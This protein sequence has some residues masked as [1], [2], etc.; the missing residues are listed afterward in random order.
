MYLY[1]T[2]KEEPSLLLR[3][4]LL[5]SI[6]LFFAACAGKPEKTFVYAPTAN[7]ADELQNL[8]SEMRRTET[9]QIAFFAP[10][11]YERSVKAWDRA[12]KKQEKGAS[13]SEVL[14]ELSLSRSYFEQAR[15]VAD[16]ALQS[17][18][19]IAE[20]RER[21]L[22]AG[23]SR[24]HRSDL[25]DADEDLIK[26]TKSFEKKNPDVSMKDRTRLQSRYSSL[27][28][29]SIKASRLGDTV[30]NIE[31][32]EKMGAAK[33][34]PRTL[35]SA[36]QKLNSAEL[37]IN[38]DRHNDA[39]VS[40]AQDEA[41]RESLKLLRVNELSKKSGSAGN[42][43]M[44]LDIFNRDQQI[45]ALNSRVSNQESE[46]TAAQRSAQAAQRELASRRQIEEMITAIQQKFSPSEAEVLRQGE[47]LI[48]RLKA[49]TFGSGKTEVS[50][51]AHPVLAKVTE[52]IQMANASKVIVEGHSDTV[53][54]A[55]ANQKISQARAESVAGFLNE[56]G[57][58]KTTGSSSGR[59]SASMDSS[60]EAR[61]YGARH[62]VA[63]NA[64]KVGR[65]QNRRVDVVITPS[66]LEASEKA[67]DRA[68]DQ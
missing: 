14:E 27:E 25:E 10:V 31:A 35:A 34:A 6:C 40:V 4:C 68:A 52:A 12:Q 56:Q 63:T 7:S 38:A 16:R 5:I 36:H 21:A 22:M 55:E 66:A 11:S 39:V 8:K 37:T 53:G 46:L 67:N 57:A 64:T 13:N 58:L 17:M 23:A 32:A 15:G 60:I 9:E 59:D 61:G 49:V 62:P 50:S 19:E 45:S 3:V 54:S 24:Y 51:A 41:F 1:S 29:R 2:E 43:P 26:I 33:Y 47:N 48:V 42:E 44:A 30:S 28:L 20:A 65:A 18:P